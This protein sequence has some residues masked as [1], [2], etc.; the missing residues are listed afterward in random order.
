MSTGER[1]WSSADLYGERRSLR[2]GC[3]T[4]ELESVNP[5]SNY[6]ADLFYCRGVGYDF[7]VRGG[8]GS[9]GEAGTKTV[10]LLPLHP[11]ADKE[12]S[13]AVDR[14]AGHLPSIRA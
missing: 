12:K 9:I 3:F 11:Q 7:L 10:A 6:V 2:A 8:I 4:T 1:L 14:G 5:G 13:T